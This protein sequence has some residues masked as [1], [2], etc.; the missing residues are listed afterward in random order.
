MAM[1]VRKIFSWK[2]LRWVVLGLVV[3]F[4]GIQ[5]VPV[6]RTNPPVEAD[7][8]ASPEVRAILRRA[9]YD[10]HSNET[11]WPWYSR[12]APVS[13]LVAQDVHEGRA[14]LN[15]S[16]WDRYTTQQQVKK[17]KESLEEVNEGEMPPWFYLPVHRDAALTAQDRATLHQWAAGTSAGGPR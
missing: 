5:L 6:D 11:V 14:E 4:A 1:N 15:F 17:L 7:V 10:C 12:V 3:V 9:C 13:W 8:P 2:Y 16:T